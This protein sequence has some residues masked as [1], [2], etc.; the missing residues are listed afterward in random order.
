MAAGRGVDEHRGDVGDDRRDRV[1]GGCGLRQGS[2]AARTASPIIRTVS[3]IIRTV[4]PI[5][6]YR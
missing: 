5:N 1:R 4:S 3:P 6:S 2:K